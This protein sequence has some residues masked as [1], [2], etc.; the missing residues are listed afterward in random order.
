MAQGRKLLSV[1]MVSLAVV[2][3]EKYMKTKRKK[4]QRLILKM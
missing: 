2:M 3:S 1:D 4:C